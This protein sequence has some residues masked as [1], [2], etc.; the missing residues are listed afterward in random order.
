MTEA[1]KDLIRRMENAI[2]NKR[3]LDAT[4]EFISP[5][6]VLR[7]APESVPSGR[8]GVRGS[9][10]AYLAGFSDLHVK[11]DELLA[12]GDRVIALLTYTGTHDG[13]SVRHPGD[14]PPRL[15]APARHLP[16]RG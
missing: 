7:T 5:K 8:D 3:N 9:M 11:V 15:R 4:D 14:W 1:N 13:D 12:D 6:Y 16:Y 2:F 10:A